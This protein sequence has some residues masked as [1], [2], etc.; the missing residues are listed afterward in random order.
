[1]KRREFSI[2]LASAGLSTI[3][4]TDAAHAQGGEPVE[5]K[6]YARVNPP[7]AAGSEDKIEVV[8]FFW[9]GC[10]HC[11]AFEPALED[12]I[13]RLPA[14]VMFKR[15][16]VAFRQDPFVA[17]QKLYFALE[18]M[19]L[20]EKLQRKVFDELH[21]DRTKGSKLSNPAEISEFVA[22]QG[23]DKAQFLSV[24]NSFA[25]NTKL[26]QAQKLIA[27]YQINGVPALG[28][29]GRFLTDGPM[30]GSMER[31]LLVADFL[32]QKVRNKV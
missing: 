18:S 21:R 6:Q 12:W 2:G 1:M 19:G 32:I 9:Y 24:Y 3:G 14:D 13:R 17:H 20:V 10:P 30:A 7:V 16:P 11:Y 23:L 15:V 4:L 8:E 25:V 26:V 28:I 5:G 31:A 29:H 22:K 27:A